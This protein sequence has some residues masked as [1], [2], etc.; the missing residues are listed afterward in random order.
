MLYPAIASGNN[1]KASKHNILIIYAKIRNT[2]K[3]CGLFFN[4]LYNI[5]DFAIKRIAKRIQG[6]CAYC[7][8]LFHSVKCV[9]R[10]ALL[11]YKII[12]RYILF[13]Q[14]FVKRLITDHRCNFIILN[15]LTILNILSIPIHII[16]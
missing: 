7:L 9:C 4:K 11:I 1:F 10:K 6:F 12:F 16:F 3:C 2:L 5:A 15:S 8:A 13:K 14:R